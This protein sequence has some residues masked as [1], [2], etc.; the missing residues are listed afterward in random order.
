[1][2]TWDQITALNVNDEKISLE[3]LLRHAKWQEQLT[4]VFAARDAALS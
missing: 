4:F 2:T 1:M 3:D